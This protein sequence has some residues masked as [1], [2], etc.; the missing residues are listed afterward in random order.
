MSDTLIS[1]LM[2]EIGLT[3]WGIF[4][5]TNDKKVRPISMK[6]EEAWSGLY[7]SGVGDIDVVH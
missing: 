4:G 7:T 3:G 6:M 2:C 5:A 1:Q